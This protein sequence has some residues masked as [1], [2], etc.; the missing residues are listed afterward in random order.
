MEGETFALL[1][2]SVADDQQVVQR[3]D[4]ADG[5]TGIGSLGLADFFRFA[6]GDLAVLDQGRTEGV[7]LQGTGT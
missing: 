3:F 5:G 1:G 7:D 6:D 4:L 2:P